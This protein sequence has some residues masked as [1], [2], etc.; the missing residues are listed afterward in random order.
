L[1]QIN[2]EHIAGFCGYRLEQG[3]QIAT[4]N[5]NLR[6]LRRML[7][8]ADEWELLD[9]VPK[10]KLLR[11]ERHRERVLS[12]DE[13]EKY[14]AAAPELL[15]SVATVLLDTGMRPEE[16][17]RLR[18]E[19]VN[20]ETGKNGTIFVT[21]G[22]TG[23][24]RRVI[25]MSGRV[26]GLLQFHWESQGKPLEGF[27]WSAK[28]RSDHIVA[29]SLKRQHRRALRE[30]GVIPFVL[31]TL[32]HTF[33]TRLGEAG[34]DAWTLARIAGHSS[35]RL[36]TRYVHPSD[37]AVHEAMKRLGGHNFGHNAISPPPSSDEK[38][39]GTS[40]NTKGKLVDV[41]GLEPVTPGLQS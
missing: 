12:R 15:R 23:A 32:R 2:G 33:L 29:S 20:W 13:E 39:D 21:S 19:A 37:D 6:V 26:R 18:W 31:Y 4:V 10:V 34:C 36:S 41:T 38:E 25:P 11:G 3:L 9:R 27:V 5:S 1:D 7:N 14:L 28:T 24:A 35:I 22:K 17:F 8:L 40:S 30:S 16:L